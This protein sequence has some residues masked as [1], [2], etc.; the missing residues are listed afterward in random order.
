[1]DSAAILKV[2]HDELKNV[3]EQMKAIEK[4]PVADRSTE[5]YRVLHDYFEKEKD[6][7]K[8]IETLEGS[9]KIYASIHEFCAVESL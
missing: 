1:M 6:L 7:I 3:K 4:I 2:L 9:L 5:V 8:K